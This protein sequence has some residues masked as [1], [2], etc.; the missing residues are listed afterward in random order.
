MSH[1]SDDFLTLDTDQE[2]HAWLQQHAPVADNTF[3]QALRAEAQRRERDNPHTALEVA[4]A[5]SAAASYWRDQPTQAVALHI[6][7]DAQRLLA[8]YKTSLHLYEAAAALYRALGFELEAARVAVGQIATMQYLSLFEEAL[9][10]ATWA[11]DIFQ[12]AGDQLALGKMMMNQGN[13]A[14]RLGNFSVARSHYAQARTIFTQIGDAHLLAMVNANDAIALTFLDDF[15]QAESLFQ[16]VRAHFV[17]QQMASA[18]ARVDLNLAYLYFAQGDYQ[19]ALAT[20]NQAKKIFSQQNNRIEVARIDLHRSDIYLA[21]NLW[22]DA[23]REAREA[24]SVFAAADVGWETAVLWLNEAAA[25]ARLEGGHSPDHALRQ[26]RQIFA[27]EQNTLWLGV[28]DLY[29]AIFDW[30]RGRLAPARENA[31]RAAATFRQLD[32][33][34]RTA[35]CEI[36]LGEIALAVKDVASAAEHFTQA[37]TQLGAADVPA[38][39]FAAHYGLAR[40]GQSQKQRAGALDHYRQAIGH[41]ERLQTAIGAEDYKIAFL[42]DKLQVYEGLIW[43]CLASDHKERQYEAF[44]TIEQA[45]SRTL[46]DALA[47]AEQSSDSSTPEAALLAEMKRL[48]REL[49]WYYNRLRDPQPDTITLALQQADQLICAITKR[50]RAL[51]KLLHQWRLPDL[52]AAP[53]NPVWTV[54]VEQ[55]QA[56]LPPETL[57]LEFFIAQEQIVVFGLTANTVWSY[58]LPVRASQIADYLAQLRF[59]MNKFSYGPAYRQRH[60]AVLQQ[61]TQDTLYHLYQALLAPLQARV[62]AATLVIVPH[63]LLHY[64]PFHALYDGRRYL[65]ET[66]TVSYAPSATVLYRVLQA[67]T[68]SGQNPPLILGLSDPAIPYAQMEAEA[69]AELFPEAIVRV[70]T[71][72]TAESLL[73]AADRPAFLHLSTH[74][75][76]RADNPLFSA[77]KLADGWLTVNEIYRLKACAPL[78]TL[79]AC[80]TGRTQV[81]VGDELVGLCRSFFAAGAQTLLISLWTVDDRAT[82]WLM[83]CFYRELQAGK[84]PNQALREAQTAVMAEHPHPYYWAAFVLTGD[85]KTTLLS[86]N[87]DGRTQ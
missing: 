25:L 33:H 87:N 51:H 53:R 74:A 49:N 56:V 1:Q 64:V 34:S 17:S 14:A 15:R 86:K 39:A 41:I 61:S 6:E 48:K 29:Q 44:A 37:L 46:L 77:L 11:S 71:A 9:A 54:N 59:Q 40:T 52:I 83:Q 5:V 20:F 42:E 81:A 62:T 30:R 12:A 85:F 4:Q 78:V 69:V 23:L 45:K 72:A 26:A 75:T 32:L 73:T 19:Y 67:E 82:A 36:V 58:R 35:H 70:G 7:A 21:L 68:A 50:E 47:R 65:I 16:Q 79:S 2:R 57:L 24:R 10:L 13:M 55:V 38:T 60:T 63:G 8:D 84:P 31:R 43:L 22:S 28:T 66:K 3:I 80:E 27:T 76:F 18:V